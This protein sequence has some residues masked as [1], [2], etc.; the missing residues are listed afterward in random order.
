MRIGLYG[1]TFD[2]VHLAHLIVAEQCREQ[3][4]LD[5]VWLMPAALNP[6]KL[7]REISSPLHRRTMLEYAIAGQ[8]GFRVEPMELERT[9]PSFTVDTLE[10]LHQ[11]HPDVCWSL[12]MGADS[13]LEFGTWKKPERI[14]ELAELVVVNRG[15]QPAADLPAF[16]ERFGH[17]FR[18]VEIPALEISASDLRQRVQQE[19]SIRYF[20]PRAVEVYIQQQGLYR[21]P[22]RIEQ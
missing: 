19:K 12:L 7:G 5:E 6:H 14:L 10:E 11:R 18:Q 1:G 13:V 21:S 3:A 8:P 9:G 2:P 16:I 4:E 17:S 22:A 20:V 15:G